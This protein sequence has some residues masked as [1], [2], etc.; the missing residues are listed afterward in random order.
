MI[1]DLA[2]YRWG[3]KKEHALSTFDEVFE[4]IK[5]AINTRT[6]V[7]LAEVLDIRQSSISD[8]KRRDSVPAEWYLKLFKKFGLNPDWLEEGLGP[9]YLKNKH[10]EYVPSDG[11]LPE[12]GVKAQYADFSGPDNKGT[13]VTI[14]SM[15]VEGEEPDK[16]APLPLGKLNI[17]QSFAKPSIQVLKVSASSMEPSIRRGAY[18]GVDTAHTHIESGEIYA[19]YIP[20]EGLALKRIFHDP[21][22]SRFILRS[23]N[24]NHP[25]QYL[26]VQ[27]RGDRIYGR[28]VWVLQEI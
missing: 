5:M 18:V 8:A 19:L 9:W 21:E 17:P 14:H 23:E 6:Q 26:P 24:P 2:L 25:E 13:L 3:E 12:S 20:F 16:W 11:P 15:Q 27:K 4:R 28:A 10:G 22:N 1:I 7:Q